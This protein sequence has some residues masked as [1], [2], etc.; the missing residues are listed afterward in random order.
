MRSQLCSVLRQRLRQPWGREDLVAASKCWIA[1]LRQLE[2]IC[3]LGSQRVVAE[4]CVLANVEALTSTHTC[5]AIEAAAALCRLSGSHAHLSIA[6]QFRHHLFKFWE[7]QL[8]L[9]DLQ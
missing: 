2:C 9:I 8:D 7:E 4:M 5:A 3:M 6:A 1:D